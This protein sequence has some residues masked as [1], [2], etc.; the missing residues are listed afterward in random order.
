MGQCTSSTGGTAPPESISNSQHASADSSN[1]LQPT[2]QH[3]IAGSS[4]NVELPFMHLHDES[5]NQGRG[6]PHRYDAFDSI[7]AFHTQEQDAGIIMISD[8]R[9]ALV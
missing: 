6:S 8:L 7:Q 3:A 1:K 2:A 9:E 5:P 4:N